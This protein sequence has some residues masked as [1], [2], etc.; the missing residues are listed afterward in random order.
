MFKLALW[1][2]GCIRLSENQIHQFNLGKLIC[3]LTSQDHPSKFFLVKGHSANI[4]K[5]NKSETGF[6]RK[7][8]GLN[9]LIQTLEKKEMIYVCESSTVK[10]YD[11][12]GLPA[13][14][15]KAT[16]D[17]DFNKGICFPIS[18]RKVFS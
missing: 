7:Y 5:K 16:Y 3:L 10:C 1:N 11:N 12:L 18:I 15:I 17:N 6:P 14:K 9:A 4:K 2:E 13:F 8:R